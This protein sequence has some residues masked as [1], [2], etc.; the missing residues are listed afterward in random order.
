MSN[1]LSFI[2]FHVYGA[3]IVFFIVYVGRGDSSEVFLCLV[4]YD[5]RFVDMSVYK[6]FVGQRIIV[7]DP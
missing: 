6:S 1:Y 2:M 5:T 4:N 3:C 7:F